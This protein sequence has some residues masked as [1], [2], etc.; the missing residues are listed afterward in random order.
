M[1]HNHLGPGAPSKRKRSG[2]PDTCPVCPLVKTAL[3]G[4]DYLHKDQ[5]EE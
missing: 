1:S 5:V 3:V 4:E 2:G